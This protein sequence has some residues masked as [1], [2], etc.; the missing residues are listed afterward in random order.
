VGAGVICAGDGSRHRAVMPS[1]QVMAAREEWKQTLQEGCLSADQLDD[2]Q[3]QRPCNLSNL[4]I[5]G[6]H[7]DVGSTQWPAL[8]Y[9]LAESSYTTALWFLEQYDFHP[10]STASRLIHLHLRQRLTQGE[11]MSVAKAE[12][13]DAVM[14][15]LL[16]KTPGL[17]PSSLDLLRLALEVCPAERPFQFVVQLMIKGVS[18]MMAHPDGR[19]ALAF[20]SKAVEDGKAW[21]AP[22]LGRLK[23]FLEGPST[24][25]GQRRGTKRK[26]CDHALPDVS[27]H[28]DTSFHGCESLST[29]RAQALEAAPRH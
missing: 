3:A 23:Q 26:A 10:K 5:E 17:P 11:H 13:W 6:W 15:A 14:H 21:A 18:P 29:V 1:V 7:D 12:Q 4:T 9:L 27:G 20:L 16:D 28:D 8:E 24:R 2:L 19:D 25:A 22:A